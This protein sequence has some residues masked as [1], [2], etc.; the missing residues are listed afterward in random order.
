MLED[1]W[2]DAPAGGAT[3]RD[4][5]R[6]KERAAGL[7]VAG[8]SLLSISKNGSS[9]SYSSGF[10]ALTSVEVANTWRDLINLFDLVAATLAST[11]DDE[12]YAEM[13][14]RLVPIREFTRDFTGLN[15]A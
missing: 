3:L 11:D 15:C 14:R 12:I 10:G 13:K 8:G 9:H 2:D 4:T 7:V 6:V 5:L 1:A